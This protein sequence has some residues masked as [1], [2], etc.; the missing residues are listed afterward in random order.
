MAIIGSP[1]AGDQAHPYNEQRNY[2]A[3]RTGGYMRNQRDEVLFGDRLNTGL[4]ALN[5]DEPV[6]FLYGKDGQGRPCRLP[7]SSSMLSRH[8]MLLGGIGTGKSNS[9]YQILDQISH[10]LTP[11]DVVIIFDT[12]GDFLKNFYRQGDVV[13][14]ND[15]Q[16]VGPDGKEDYWNIFQEIGQGPNK[17]A[18][19]LE[20]AKSLFKEACEKTSQVFFPAAARDI[21]MAAMLHFI[22][23]ADDTG[24]RRFLNN[25]DFL[26]FLKSKKSYELREM[27]ESYPDLRALSLIHI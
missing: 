14:S 24:D 21:F 1:G 7:F 23:Y 11:E 3:A 13:I 5:V 15:K 19:V 22:R 26:D 12:K 16:A 9:F 27:L 25:E 18:A 20:I 4:P 6:L 8:I 2:P 10:R 17:E